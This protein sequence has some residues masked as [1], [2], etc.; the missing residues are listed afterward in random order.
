VKALPSSDSAKS[1]A[2]GDYAAIPEVILHTVGR[3]GLLTM[4]LYLAG[5]R[6]KELRKYA[7]AGALSIEAFAIAWFLLQRKQGEAI[8]FDPNAILASLPE[9]LSGL[10]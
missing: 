7:V 9:Y 6:G 8:Q 5:A 2:L 10:E 4:G 3:A 1:L